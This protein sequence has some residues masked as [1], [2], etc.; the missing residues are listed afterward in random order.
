MQHG[1]DA[2]DQLEVHGDEGEHAEQ[3]L[4]VGEAE[5]FV[6]EDGAAGAHG[7]EEEEELGDGAEQE[8][9][10]LGVGGGGGEDAIDGVRLGRTGKRR[11]DME[12]QSD[13]RREV[14]R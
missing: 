6:A 13:S 5:E 3:L 14:T 8:E 4:C 12:L 10:G 1:E 2:V 7:V 11:V 9:V